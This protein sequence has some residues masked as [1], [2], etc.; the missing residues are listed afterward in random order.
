M[1]NKE[2]LR[3]KQVNL[4]LTQAEYERLTRTAQDHGIG[5]AAYLRMVLRGEQYYP[6]LLPPKTDTTEDKLLET[7]IRQ[8]AEA[9]GVNEELKARNQMAGV[10]AMNNIKSAALEILRESK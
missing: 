8:M 9:Q 5:R 1:K 3:E 6:C 10:G 2:N 4:H 7:I